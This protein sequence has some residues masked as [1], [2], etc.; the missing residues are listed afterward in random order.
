MCY[1][2]STGSSDKA[3]ML[4]LDSKQCNK[5]QPVICSYI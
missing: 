5:T 1:V 4:C 2:T 3:A